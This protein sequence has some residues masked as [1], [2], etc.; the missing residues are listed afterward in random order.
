ME[1]Q[2]ANLVLDVN[3]LQNRS[4]FSKAAASEEVFLATQKLVNAIGN[5]NKSPDENLLVVGGIES[6]I[7]SA[8]GSSNHAQKNVNDIAKRRLRNSSHVEG[9]NQKRT[10]KNAN[11]FPVQT[12][13]L[14]DAGSNVVVEMVSY[15]HESTSG[16]QNQRHNYNCDCEVSNE[17]YSAENSHSSLDELSECEEVAMLMC[18]EEDRRPPPLSKSNYR[19][20]HGSSVQKKRKTYDPHG[21]GR[22]PNH[23][24]RYGE[25]DALLTDSEVLNA[26]LTRAQASPRCLTTA[27]P[28]DATLPSYESVVSSAVTT[29]GH[30]YN[31]APICSCSQQP[32]ST[33]HA[34][35]KLTCPPPSYSRHRTQTP[36]HP[37][38]EN[39]G[40]AIQPCGTPQLTLTNSVSPSRQNHY[41]NVNFGRRSETTPSITSN[42][43]NDAI[44]TS[45][46]DD[47]SSAELLSERV[48]VPHEVTV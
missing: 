18:K 9:S 38:A 23:R 22:Y 47:R 4:P 25:S 40:P 15:G 29:S 33:H 2:R 11:T 37:R 27:P 12:D 31:F 7:N 30:M 5:K 20:T 28:S 32:S 44:M 45:S 35:Q 36:Q 19:R 41:C 17:M 16:A 6:N 24:V 42:G 48:K 14:E 3:H 39:R 21:R 13:T 1:Q 8:S 34:E 46:Y 10:G 26:N 43:S